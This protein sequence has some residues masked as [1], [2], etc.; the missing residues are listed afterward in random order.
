MSVARFEAVSGERRLMQIACSSSPD[1][2]KRVL[3]TVIY[4]VYTLAAK[5]A[6]E[7]A[8]S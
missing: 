1:A 7:I 5:E 3:H 2:R 6:F 4:C 8:R